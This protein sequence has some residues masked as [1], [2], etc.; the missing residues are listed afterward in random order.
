MQKKSKEFNSFISKE[1]VN[2]IFSNV[3]EIS[4]IHKKFLDD[5]NTGADMGSL[6]NCYVNSKE[7]RKIL[8][9]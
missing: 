4:K 8:I 6:F 3:E 7:K 5:M 1:D 2:K 9:E